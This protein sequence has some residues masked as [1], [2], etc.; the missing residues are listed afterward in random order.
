VGVVDAARRSVGQGV[1]LDE[2]GDDDGLGK[3]SPF[4]VVGALEEVKQDFGFDHVDF[5]GVVGQ[6]DRS[7]G[8]PQSLAD[9]SEELILRGVV[10]AGGEFLRDIL[11]VVL[12]LAVESEELSVLLEGPLVAGGFRVQLLDPTD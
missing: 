1:V 2:L 12:F 3:G 7:T 10:R 5:G 9:Q 4:H 11:P 8:L 6:A